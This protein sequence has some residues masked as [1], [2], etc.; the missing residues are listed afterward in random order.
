MLNQIVEHIFKI[1]GQRLINPTQRPVSG[2]DI[3]KAFVIGDRTR[4]YFVKTNSALRLGMFEVEAI[5]LSQIHAT[6]IIKVPEPICWGKT[7]DLAYIVI[8][9]IEFGRIENWQQLGRKLAAMHEVKS[10]MGFGWDRQNT[11]GF[12]PQIN[13]WNSNWIDFFI[14]HRLLYQ[15]KLARQKGF[16]PIISDR[17]LCERVPKFFQGYDPQP[18][19]VHGDLWSGNVGFDLTGEPVIF[20]P[21]LY[22][23]DREVDIAMT[24]LFGGFPPEF[25]QSYNAAFPLDAGYK[26]RKDLYNLYHILNHFNLFG[27]SYGVMA[28]R[29]I[30]EIMMLEV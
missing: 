30:E 4:K 11:I 28:T 29:A 12:T 17:E 23:G 1:T 9:W 22:F 18:S 10:S 26:Y 5:A 13:T 16:K 15:L 6:Q 27:G 21:A 7:S 25:Y 8:D 3:S 2:G 19:M 20:D 14:E 24:E